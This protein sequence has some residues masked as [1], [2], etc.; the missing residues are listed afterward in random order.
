[1]PT[2]RIV[3]AETADKRHRIVQSY[4][5]SGMEGASITQGESAAELFDVFDEQVEEGTA[6]R[7]CVKGLGLYQGGR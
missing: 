7:A 6:Y 3:I 2:F 4:D 5:A 1:M